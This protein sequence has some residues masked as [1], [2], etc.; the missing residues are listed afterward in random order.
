MGQWLRQLSLQEEIRNEENFHLI[1]CRVFCLFKIQKKTSRKFSFR[2]KVYLM[3]FL[4]KHHL[5]KNRKA[6]KNPRDQNYISQISGIFGIFTN[7][8]P[9]DFKRAGKSSSFDPSI[10]SRNCLI[11][12]SLSRARTGNKSEIFTLSLLSFKSWHDFSQVKE[13]GGREN[14]CWPRGWHTFGPVL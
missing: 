8:H 1:S 11:Q 13:G 10:C 7:R 9:A 12:N 5:K 4:F 14:E 2:P 3:K 6:E